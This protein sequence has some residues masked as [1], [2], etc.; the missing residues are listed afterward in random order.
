MCV[1]GE[2]GRA[3]QRSE[4]ERSRG[5]VPPPRL[6]IYL[7]HG[8]LPYLCGL[9]T[10][11]TVNHISVTISRSLWHLCAV[12][13]LNAAAGRSES[14]GVSDNEEQVLLLNSTTPL[15]LHF[16]NNQKTTGNCSDLCFHKN[17]EDTD[18]NRLTG[19]YTRTHF[20]S[21]CA[22]TSSGYQYFTHCF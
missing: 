12:S 4:M 20:L 18:F 21:S 9:I 16:G 5:A 15:K 3:R 13:V 7:A 14:A 17:V 6:V 11:R 1:Y 10:V 2:A 19:T 8:L 22:R